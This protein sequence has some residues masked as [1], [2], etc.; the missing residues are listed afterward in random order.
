MADKKGFAKFKAED[1]KPPKLGPP[2]MSKE[3]KVA[4]GRKHEMTE[5]PEEEKAE[6]SL[7]GKYVPPEAV[8]YRTAE[9]KCGN[10]E[11]MEASGLC[12]WLGMRVEEGATC[13]LFSFTEADMSGEVEEEEAE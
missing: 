13:S 9:E 3:K 8:A 7:N 11:Y 6:H 5:T 1:D 12:T 10:C 2:G 4:E